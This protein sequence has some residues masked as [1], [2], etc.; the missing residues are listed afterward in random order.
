M[1]SLPITLMALT[2]LF[3][4]T[5]T[6]AQSPAPSPKKS[7]HPHSHSPSP[8]NSPILS[9]KSVSS[10]SPSPSPSPVASSSLPPANALAPA[11]LFNDAITNT[12]AVS[13][14]LFTAVSAA[15]FLF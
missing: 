10:P 11:L 1:A 3:L 2:A 5:S 6:F 12:F 8:H 7:H 15:A 4:I 13:A 9:H 14:S